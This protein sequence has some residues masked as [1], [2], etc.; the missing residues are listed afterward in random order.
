MC[1]SHLGPPKSDLARNLPVRVAEVAKTEALNVFQQRRDSIQGPEDRP[2][3]QLQSC[4]RQGGHAP[5]CNGL[6]VRLGIE[7]QLSQRLQWRPLHAA[8]RVLQYL[9]CGRPGICAA[10]PK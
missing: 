2:V 3:E 5:S 8:E 10:N 1:A 6:R 4:L 7:A 9:F